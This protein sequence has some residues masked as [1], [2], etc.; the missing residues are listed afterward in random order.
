MSIPKERTQQERR[1]MCERRSSITSPSRVEYGGAETFS[2]LRRSAPRLGTGAW[3][4]EEGGALRMDHS[5]VEAGEHYAMPE[6]LSV[7]LRRHGI[8]RR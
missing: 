8:F 7:S 3:A 6:G 2:P 5:W 4:L 1:S